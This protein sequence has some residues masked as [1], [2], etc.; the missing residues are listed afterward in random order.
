[1]IIILDDEYALT[2]NGVTN[3]DKLYEAV[4]PKNKWMILTRYIN[5]L[6][7]LTKI[8]YSWKGISINDVLKGDSQ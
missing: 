2:E 1:M 8:N 7:R 4:L 3:I 6:N 5:L